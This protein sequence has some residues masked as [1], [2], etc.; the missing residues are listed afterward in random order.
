MALH[1]KGYETFCQNDQH[2]SNKEHDL[3]GKEDMGIYT[4]GKETS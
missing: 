2:I 4:F 1:T 3:D